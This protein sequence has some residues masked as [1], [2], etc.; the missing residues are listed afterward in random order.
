MVNP[1]AEL[2]EKVD[3]I[4]KRNPRYKPEAY[5]FV[6]AALHFSVSQLPEHRHITG[7]ELLAGIRVYALDQFGPLA[8]Q[9]FGHWGITSTLDFGRIVFSLVEEKLLGKTEEDSLA[10]FKGVYDFAEAFDPD[11]LFKLSDE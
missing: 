10:D 9:V 11:P 7:R 3:R 5:L 4:T 2:L 6:L 8:R 1:T